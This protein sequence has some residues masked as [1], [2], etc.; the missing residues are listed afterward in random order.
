LPFGRIPFTTTLKVPG[1]GAT[2]RL[3]VSQLVITYADR[4]IILFEI[5]KRNNLVYNMPVVVP[6]I[7][8]LLLTSLQLY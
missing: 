7:L 4:Y 6:I 2:T 1:V 8:L 5:K 3:K